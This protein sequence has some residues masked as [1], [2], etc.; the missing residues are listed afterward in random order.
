MQPL[1]VC[2]V[3]SCIVYTTLSAN[4][5]DRNYPNIGEARYVCKKQ[6]CLLK[7]P[8]VPWQDYIEDTSIQFNSTGCHVC[9][10]MCSKFPEFCG[11]VEC[12]GSSRR[13]CVF[14]NLDKCIDNDSPNF[15]EY[16][17][18]HFEKWGYTCYKTISTTT[19]GVT[20]SSTDASTSP[21]TIGSTI[22]SV[23]TDINCQDNTYWCLFVSLYECTNE[24]VKTECAKTCQTCQSNA[25]TT[26]TPDFTRTTKP[27]PTDNSETTGTLLTTTISVLITTSQLLSTY[28]STSIGTELSSTMTTPKLSTTQTLLSTDSSTTPHTQEST[29]FKS[30]ASISTI[31][32][33][34]TSTNMNTSQI[35][36]TR[37]IKTTLNPTKYSDKNNDTG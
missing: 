1:L 20:D 32:N 30:E 4:E 13:K 33:P 8:Y 37:Q 27:S 26:V 9:Q 31:L 7:P 3:F 34:S 2:V 14:W 5:Y 21:K 22:T 11:A 16:T 18:I 17:E 12:D 36:K 24:R 23:T 15:F 29:T 6:G 35:M 28:Y 10:S 25:E 19:I